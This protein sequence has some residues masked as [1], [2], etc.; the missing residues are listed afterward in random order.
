ME[1]QLTDVQTELDRIQ[2]LPIEQRAEALEALIERLRA[3][4]EEIASA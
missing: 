3:S 4:L 2:T 1:T